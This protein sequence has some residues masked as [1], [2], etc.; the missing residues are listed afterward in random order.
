MG[1]AKSMTE[2]EWLTSTDVRRLTKFLPQPLSRRKCV[3]AVCGYGWRIVGY[4]PPV[5][6]AGYLHQG[7]DGAD[8]RAPLEVDMQN[9]EARL[10]AGYRPLGRDNPPAAIRGG[11]LWSLVAASGERPYL[12]PST[13]QAMCVAV[14]D[15]RHP[16]G[17][18]SHDPR[19]HS[20]A[21][22]QVFD[23]EATTLA[24]IVRDVFGNPFRPVSADH[25]WL[26]TTVVALAR[27]IYETR[28]FGA[29]PILADALQDAGCEDDAILEHCR[30][31]K[32]IHVRGCWAVDLLLEKK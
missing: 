19:N 26:T 24:D 9:L 30:D 27:E 22:V 4:I 15:I 25:S 20:R 13:C 12:G 8:G 17:R 3:L 28:D 31:E 1:K 16:D 5:D 32:V 21:W 11:L 23:A 6:V 14:A 10:N 18:C 29:M 7:E 2:A